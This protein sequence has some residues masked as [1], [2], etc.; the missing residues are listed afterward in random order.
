MSS[1]L[2]FSEAIL[3]Y[4]KWKRAMPKLSYINTATGKFFIDFNMHWTMLRS[5]L[6]VRY[7]FI[8]GEV[9]FLN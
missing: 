9:S 7:K 2:V 5:V 1:Y 6:H 4:E 3:Q 8:T